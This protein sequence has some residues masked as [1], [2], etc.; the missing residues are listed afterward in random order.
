MNI[1]NEWTE[2]SDGIYRSKEYENSV[3]EL[4]I[5]NWK[6]STDILSAN[7]ALYFR[8]IQPWSV[9]NGHVCRTC[10]ENHAPLMSC[11][12][13]VKEHSKASKQLIKFINRSCNKSPIE[14]TRCSICTHCGMEEVHYDDDD[15]DE[16]FCELGKSIFDYYGYFDQH[17]KEFKLK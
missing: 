17:C 16:P 8:N 9:K 1:F 7:C 10:L 6:K 4:L 12:E 11:L 5:L 2:V 14:P 15:Y 3:Y 13:I